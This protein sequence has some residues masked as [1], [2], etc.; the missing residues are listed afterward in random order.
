[1]TVYTTADADVAGTVPPDVT[2]RHKRI[3]DVISSGHD[4]EVF[5]SVVGNSHF[6]VPFIEVLESVDTVVITH[7]TRLV[8]LYLALRDRGG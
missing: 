4:H 6:H 5:V 8:E 7:D 2:V 1:M 3:D